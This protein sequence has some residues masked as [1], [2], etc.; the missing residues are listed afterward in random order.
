MRLSHR[1]RNHER[2]E[3]ERGRDAELVLSNVDKMRIKIN[4]NRFDA[5][6]DA[7]ACVTYLFRTN[8]LFKSNA[9]YIHQRPIRENVRKK[10]YKNVN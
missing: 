1:Q 9:N 3:R 6:A 8:L 4:V 10:P 5:V 7:A 2:N